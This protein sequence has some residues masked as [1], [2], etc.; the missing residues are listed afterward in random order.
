[1]RR[2]EEGGGGGGEHAVHRE[3]LVPRLIRAGPVRK[4][5]NLYGLGFVLAP[6]GDCGHP[7]CG[8]A[9][10]APLARWSLN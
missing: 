8:A 7:D 9:R 1:M 4:G 3:V 5:R 2:G 10:V 6:C